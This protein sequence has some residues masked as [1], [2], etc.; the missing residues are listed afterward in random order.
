MLARSGSRWLRCRFVGLGSRRL[1][2]ARLLGCPRR[3]HQAHLAA[4]TPEPQ[5]VL[6]PGRGQISGVAEPSVRPDLDLGPTS[7]SGLRA[8]FTRFDENT[9]SRRPASGKGHR[10]LPEVRACEAQR[11][12]TASRP[13]VAVDAGCRLTGGTG[14][15]QGRA[16]DSTDR[17]QSDPHVSVTSRG[18]DVP[19]ARVLVGRYPVTAGSTR[20]ERRRLLRASRPRASASRAGRARRCG[21][22]RPPG[23]RPRRPRPP[24]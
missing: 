19:S 13:L 7:P 20:R 6:R 3:H 10:A 11:A 8:G 1:R 2:R 16:R 12:A 18:S 24:G 23:R 5:P 17:S 14:R 15:G 9:S 21:G 4:G 22:R